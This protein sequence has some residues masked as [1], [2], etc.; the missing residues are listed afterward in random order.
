M[1]LQKDSK[2]GFAEKVRWGKNL[3]I[4]VGLSVGNFYFQ[5]VFVLSSCSEQS[6]VKF[7]FLVFFYR[8][9][10]TD[11]ILPFVFFFAGVNGTALSARTERQKEHCPFCPYK[12]R[13]KNMTAI[14]SLST[15]LLFFLLLCLSYFIIAFI[16]QVDYIS[17]VMH[18]L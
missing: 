12:T 7:S 17:R 6:E 4:C 15:G 9:L 11:R 18:W 2:H 8:L 1:L 10:L 3:N 14:F 13:K 5:S 16:C